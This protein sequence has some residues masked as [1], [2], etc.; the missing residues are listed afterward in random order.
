MSAFFDRVR[1]GESGNGS[2][3]MEAL[4]SLTFMNLW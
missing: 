4:D 2:Q 3:E 1:V